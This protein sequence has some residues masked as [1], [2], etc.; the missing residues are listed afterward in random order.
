MKVAWIEDV[1]LAERQA[2]DEEGNPMFEEDGT[3][4][5]ME[6]VE[7]G[8]GTGVVTGI[9]R[10]AVEGERELNEPTTSFTKGYV[11]DYYEITFDSVLSV[12]SAEDIEAQEFEK[13]K[14][15]MQ[16]GYKA[17]CTSVILAKYPEPIQ[18]SAALG[19][20]PNEY[21]DDMVAFLAYNIEEENRLNDAVS[22]ATTDEEL[23]LIVPAFG[24]IPTE[25]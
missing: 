9:N 3:T 7:V 8:L 10:G 1:E 16:G 22:E 6:Q 19:V 4:P 14:A 20:Y 23:D 24:E 12:K 11:S 2:V 15:S 18:R 13:R 5:I 17:E 21:N 25:V